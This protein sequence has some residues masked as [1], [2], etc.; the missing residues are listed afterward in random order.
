MMDFKT[1][2]K[3]VKPLVII[4]LFAQQTSMQLEWL[5]VGLLFFTTT[6]HM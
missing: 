6:L 2:F 3:L 5:L 1:S 4:F